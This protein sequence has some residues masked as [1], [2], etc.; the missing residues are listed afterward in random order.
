MA[1]NIFKRSNVAVLACFLSGAITA[2][3]FSGLS[4]QNTP[5]E[6]SA[7][8]QGGRCRSVRFHAS[9]PRYF[10][11][12]SDLTTKSDIGLVGRVS[13]ISEAVAPTDGSPPY[14]MITVDTEKTAWVADSRKDNPKQV[15]FM[16]SGGIVEGVEYLL[17][18]DPLIELDERIV[19]ALDEYSPGNYRLVGGPSGRFRL[20][21]ADEV[22]PVVED[23]IQVPAGRTLEM[24]FN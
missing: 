12:I 19:V 16:Q 9:W 1:I 5:V 7:K 18:G 24:L 2:F 23:G 8:D 17:E 14:R 10:R 4:Q 15:T 3:N 20:N 13:N 11:R 21:A 22:V 6:H